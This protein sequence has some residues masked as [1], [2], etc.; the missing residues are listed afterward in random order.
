VV[1]E[2][3]QLINDTSGPYARWT[4]EKLSNGKYAFKAD[5]GKY[6]SRC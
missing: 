2:D 1:R 3:L 4:P 5:N 6:L